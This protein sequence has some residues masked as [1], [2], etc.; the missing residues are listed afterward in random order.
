MRSDLQRHSAS[1][2]PKVWEKSVS[3]RKL[4]AWRYLTYAS[5]IYIRGLAV[6]INSMTSVDPYLGTTPPAPPSLHD[7]NRASNTSQ[8]R[9]G[10][11][12]IFNQMVKPKL[13]QNQFTARKV[14]IERVQDI[15][16]GA[17]R[18]GAILPDNSSNA[19]ESQGQAEQKW[20]AKSSLLTPP[21]KCDDPEKPHS[22]LRSSPA[23]ESIERWVIAIAHRLIHYDNRLSSI[24]PK[25]RGN[26]SEKMNSQ[27]SFELP[28]EPNPKMDRR[29]RLTNA[30]ST[31]QELES[32][33]DDGVLLLCYVDVTAPGHERVSLCSGFSVQ[34]GSSLDPTETT[35]K[36]ELVVTCAHTVRLHFA[37]TS[38]AFRC[39]LAKGLFQ[40]F[41]RHCI[42]SYSY[43]PCLS[44]SHALK[45]SSGRRL[46]SAPTSRQSALCKS[47]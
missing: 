7:T 11:S 39:I 22:P 5:R 37:L 26:F 40:R 25:L 44:H 1:M 33:Q 16:T 20:K 41:K 19:T 30:V 2:I 42:C 43:W 31:Q 28:Y 13:P 9:D 15:T 10:D 24:I 36:G 38:I 29:V 23:L 35:G 6:P 4:L 3:S 21:A 34:G 18:R 46:S 17:P 8:H 27:L 14:A 12:G 45:L 32:A 47:D